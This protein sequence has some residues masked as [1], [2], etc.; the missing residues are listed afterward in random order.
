MTT[1]AKTPKVISNEEN[2]YSIP[3]YQRLFSWTP[4]EIN[5]LLE[6]LL[7]QYTTNPNN[8][9]Y[10]GL[11]TST[12]KKDLVDGQQ[13]FTVITLMSIVLKRYYNEWSGFLFM[14]ESLRLRFRAR[15]EDATY[16]SCIAK[17]TYESGNFSAPNYTN[18]YMQA[19]L[20]T[21][22]KFMKDL[23][24]DK[25]GFSK[26]IYEHIAFFIQELPE[27]YSGR[28]LNK[29]FESMNST[30]RNLENHEILKV[31][32]LTAADTANNKE[33]Y[34]RLVTMWNKSSRMDQSILP[35]Y[36]DKTKLVFKNILEQIRNNTYI[37]EGSIIDE[38]PRTILDV[39][40]RPAATSVFR[41]ENGN[42]VMLSFMSFTD[43]LLHVLYI[44]IK[45]KGK[46]ISNLHDFFHPDNLRKTFET[47]KECVNP[48]EFIE[49]VYKFRMIYDIAILHTDKTGDYNLPMSEEDTSHLEQYE[50]MLFAST[51]RDTY[52]QWVT[53]VLN[54]VRDYGLDKDS[55]LDAL[56]QH[57][58]MNHKPDFSKMS[59]ENFEN[60]YFRRL[61]YYLWEKVINN[62]DIDRTIF[63]RDLS[64]NESSM[65]KKAIEGYKFHQYNSVEHLHPRHED[66][67]IIKWEDEAKEKDWDT[68]NCFGNLA[69]ISTHFNSKQSDDSLTL[70]FDR[71]FDQIAQ[72][73]LESIKLAMMYYCANGESKSWDQNCCKQ[74]EKLIMKIL[75]DSYSSKN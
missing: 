12:G 19:G 63:S 45:K 28:M 60:Y 21:I 14:N 8:H 48:A 65:L 75:K 37:Y 2:F 22:Q 36:D 1:Y 10:I 74:H 15:E 43:F 69:L 39:I 70:K 6:D 33:V 35:Y 5:I 57:D 67:Q 71:I 13:R 3:I 29:Y 18:V 47:Y 46:P 30:G 20:Q 58:N 4:N 24:V 53:F 38:N 49:E 34:D 32:L 41:K 27:K 52:Y 66:N 50:A 56:K 16:L 9:Y 59:Y 31:E 26:F 40:Q 73:K 11:L 51:S 61:D 55:L 64:E 68:I 17:E 72:S 44:V 7:C 25:T 54:Y 42:A 62:E 23:K